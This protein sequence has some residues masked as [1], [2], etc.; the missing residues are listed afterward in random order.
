MIFFTR[1]APSNQWAFNMEKASCTKS[2]D[3]VMINIE[4]VEKDL[5]DFHVRASEHIA[6][7]KQVNPRQL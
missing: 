4:T 3:D 7:L 2:A 1:V 6:D 5:T